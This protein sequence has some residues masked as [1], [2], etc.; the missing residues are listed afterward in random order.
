V[1]VSADVAI[2]VRG[3]SKVYRLWSTPAARLWV[4]VLQRLEVVCR[5]W[6]PL[7]RRLRAAIDRRLRFHRALEDVNFTLHRGD[8]LGIIGANG[9]GKS[10]L[11]QL[12]AGVLQQTSGSVRVNGRIAALLELGSGFNQEMTGRENVVVNAAIL[13]MKRAQIEQRMDAIIA[14][15]DIGEYID[16]PV[17][18]YSSGMVMRLAFAVQ[19]HVDPDILIVDEALSVGDARFQAKAMTR[20]DEILKRGTTLLFVGHDLNAVKSFCQHAMLLE[21]GRISLQGAPEEV[22][23]EYLFR[24]HADTLR[25]LPAATSGASERLDHG[26][27]L[28]DTCVERASINGVAHHASLR[29]GDKVQLELVIRVNPEV[30]APY[31]ILDIMDGKGMQITGRR[32]AVRAQDGQPRVTMRLAFDA[33]LQKGVYRFR[34]RLV[35]AP[36]LETTTMLSRQEGWLSFDIVDDSRERFTGLFPLPMDVEVD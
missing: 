12:V 31:L 13:G 20:I 14:F 18:T 11:L 29:Y 28:G 4:P 17:K 36:K 30:R 22:I 32:I 35:D 25:A 3:L 34:M 27:G 16:Q 33:T 1:T 23:T 26:F 24:I 8:A 5:W 7:A 15:A 19:V 10:T 9:S 21:N 2:E 6:P